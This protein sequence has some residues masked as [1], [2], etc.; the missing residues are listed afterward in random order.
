MTQKKTLEEYVEECRKIHT[1]KYDYSITKYTNWDCKIEYICPIHG[2]Q[3][4][5]ANDHRSGKGCKP[6][7]RERTKKAFAYTTERFIEACNKKHNNRYSY[8]NA[9]YIDYRSEVK[10]ECELHGEF[11]QVAGYHLSGNG[12][13]K[14]AVYNKSSGPALQPADFDEFVELSV[15]V[16]GSNYDYSLVNYEKH[17]I[18]VTIVC[19]NHG[20][21]RCTPT[22]HL[23]GKGCA[24]CQNFEAF[25][26]K[27]RSL[28][29]DKFQYDKSTYIRSKSKMRI[30]CQ[31]H[32]EFWQAP[33]EH[34]RIRGKGCS[35]CPECNLDNKRKEQKM[36]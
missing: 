9:V 28:H 36:K 11:V 2:V 19:P 29:G 31:K 14:C 35:H 32:G 10:I 15:K 26:Q 34:S 7:G 4:Q 21:F 20:P 30:V 17:Y 5:R 3:I 25:V 16:H 27:A 33:G 13:Q 12:C 24:T 6:C 23:E 18:T 22:I 8:P 1:D